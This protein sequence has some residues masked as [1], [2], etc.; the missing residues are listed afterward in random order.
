MRALSAVFRGLVRLGLLVIATPFALAMW[1]V[2]LFAAM[3]LGYGVVAV[4][5]EYVLHL[6]HTADPTTVLDW[7]ATS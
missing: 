4:V 2:Y 7:I 3:V 6:P 5:R 1:A